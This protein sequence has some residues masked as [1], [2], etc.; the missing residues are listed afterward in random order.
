MFEAGRLQSA[1]ADA[2]QAD[3]KA[4][5]AAA[6]KA[7]T[8]AAAPVSRDTTLT[9]KK[10]AKDDTLIL[11]YPNDPDTL[12]PI[13]SNDSVSDEFFRLCYEYLAPRFSRP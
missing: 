8:K 3:A 9:G 13:T 5:T 2:G 1:A 4:S 6:S 12:N 11:Y 7:D 10:P